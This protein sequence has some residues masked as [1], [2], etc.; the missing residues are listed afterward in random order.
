MVPL[1]RSLPSAC[2][3]SSAIATKCLIHPTVS[4]VAL[5]QL[6]HIHSSER[7]NVIVAGT[8]FTGLM[9]AYHLSNQFYNRPVKI[10]V[11]GKED[12]QS[13]FDSK[14]IVHRDETS[15]V[16]PIGCQ[17]QSGFIWNGEDAFK[18]IQN[19]ID[20]SRASIYISPDLDPDGVMA[21]NLYA[22]WHDRHP[23]Q[24]YDPAS[25]SHRQR[26]LVK[27]NRFAR[28]FWP[29]IQKESHLSGHSFPLH[30]EGAWRIYRTQED[31]NYAK[32]SLK[33]LQ[34]MDYPAQIVENTEQL[35]NDFPFT[36][37]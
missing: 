19:G 16:G 21:M 28:S 11:L 35:A 10:I 8:G 13:E 32:Q 12:E 2:T 24:K 17:P 34:Q 23:D 9:T 6:R 30:F 25:T 22:G 4:T 1:I 27:I 36:E 14:R 20:N 7:P 37:I 15:K 18:T 29:Q 3:A 31:L 33:I 26:A 5:S